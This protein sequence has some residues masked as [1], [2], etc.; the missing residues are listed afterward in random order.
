MS[1]T[2]MVYNGP[3]VTTAAPVKV[4]TGT[5]IKTMIQLATS[6]SVGMTVIEWGVS[7]DGVSSSAV[8][9]ECELIDVGVAATVTAYVA[10]D[11][12]KWG[13]PTGPATVAQIGSTTLSGYTASAEGTVAAT[14]R[15]L[16]LQQVSPTGGFVEQFPLGREP[17]IPVSRFLRIR[18]TAAAAVNAY[19]Y[20]IWQDI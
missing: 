7:F 5:A 19:C 17:G 18:M 4:T 6:A 2:Y 12:V 13:D 14:T 9:I 10:A 20:V 15:I 8:P 11:L 16:G 1:S 3:A